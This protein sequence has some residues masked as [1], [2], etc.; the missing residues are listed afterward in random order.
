M[1]VFA[2]PFAPEL[3]SPGRE[4]PRA[5][6]SRPCDSGFGARY[7]SDSEEISEHG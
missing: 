6:Q 7:V 5:F 2:R 3:N 4:G 1:P